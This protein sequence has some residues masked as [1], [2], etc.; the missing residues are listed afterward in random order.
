MQSRPFSPPV[1]HSSSPPPVAP[2]ARA[3]STSSISSNNSLS[4][5]TTPTVGKDLTVSVSGVCAASSLSSL[6]MLL[7][8][9]HCYSTCAVTCVECLLRSISVLLLLRWRRPSPVLFCDSL[10]SLSIN[11]HAL[12]Q[13][14]LELP[15]S[16]SVMYYTHSV[17]S[18]N[19]H[20]ISVDVVTT[21]TCLICRNGMV[22]YTVTIH[23]ARG[24]GTYSTVYYN[25]RQALIR[26]IWY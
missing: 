26:N 24:K 9:C 17:Y 19:V 5:A 8:L 22:K 7:Y 3:E 18:L 25:T 4:A 20:C 15:C 11:P 21:T 2:L 23:S 10:N 16:L 6:P 1:S 13:R 14:I 12:L